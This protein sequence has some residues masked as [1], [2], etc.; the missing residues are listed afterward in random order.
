M[1][2]KLFCKLEGLKKAIKER[3]LNHQTFEVF[4]TIEGLKKTYFR[5]YKVTHCIE[6][7]YNI[8]FYKLDTKTPYY[9]TETKDIITTYELLSNWL[10]CG[11]LWQ[12]NDIKGDE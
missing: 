5:G 9:T 3:L 10:Q 6:Q 11:D 8:T 1:E 7:Q 12:I 4:Y 2:Y